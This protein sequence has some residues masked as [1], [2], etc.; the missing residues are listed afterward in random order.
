MLLQHVGICAL[1]VIVP[2]AIDSFCDRSGN[3]I[4]SNF[5]RELVDNA[6]QDEMNHL[7]RNDTLLCDTLQ[8]VLAV[9]PLVSS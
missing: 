8:L 1:Y 2:L 3:E 7:G 5:L 9:A 6:E 4:L